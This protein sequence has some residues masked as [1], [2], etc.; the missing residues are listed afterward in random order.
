MGSMEFKALNVYAQKAVKVEIQVLRWIPLII[1]NL[2]S[3]SSEQS[4]GAAHRYFI[5]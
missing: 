5:S 1:V 4:F 3:F 2:L